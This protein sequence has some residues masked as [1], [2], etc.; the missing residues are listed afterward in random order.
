MGYFS[1]AD[2]D[3]GALIAQCT[4]FRTS[5]HTGIRRRCHYLGRCNYLLEMEMF[6]KNKRSS[7]V[8]LPPIVYFVV[9]SMESERLAQT[10]GSNLLKSWTR[11][12][13]SR[14]IDFSKIFEKIL[15][16]A[17]GLMKFSSQATWCPRAYGW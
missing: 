15:K 11:Q 1:N 6:F 7:P 4:K 13:K 3:G 17:G 9:S 14:F 10:S 16:Q 12:K 8:L 5:C 2:H